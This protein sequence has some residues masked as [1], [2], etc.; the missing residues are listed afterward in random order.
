MVF[1]VQGL[2]C[3]IWLSLRQLLCVVAG[4]MI[5]AFSTVAAPPRFFILLPSLEEKT[6]GLFEPELG[7]DSMVDDSSPLVS[8]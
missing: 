5:R 3:E 1:G 6:S 2:A 4:G 7:L 8:L